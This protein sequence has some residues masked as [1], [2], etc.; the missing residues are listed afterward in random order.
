MYLRLHCSFTQTGFF[1]KKT[2]TKQR[3]T[4]KNVHHRLNKKKIKWTRCS[5]VN[6]AHKAASPPSCLVVRWKKKNHQK[7]PLFR[8]FL[9]HKQRKSKEKEAIMMV[10]WVSSEE[11]VVCSALLQQGPLLRLWMTGPGTPKQP[12][13][14]QT[15][16]L[17]KS[18]RSLNSLVGV[19]YRVMLLRQFNNRAKILRWPASLSAS[20]SVQWHSEASV[21]CEC[22]V[23]DSSHRTCRCR[24]DWEEMN[25]VVTPARGGGHLP[26]R[27]RMLH[28]C[29]NVRKF[30]RRCGWR[31]GSQRIFSSQIFRLIPK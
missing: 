14:L 27:F 9:I 2:K 19:V 26:F 31:G 13:T 30:P 10:G 22:C 18:E 8:G 24:S 5:I 25:K 28:S 23:F 20:I 29:V 16:R 12:L 6:M 17:R 1:H 4:S 7:R 21:Q 3:I 15:S 11:D